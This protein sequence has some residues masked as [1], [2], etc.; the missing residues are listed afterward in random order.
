MMPE[1]EE[2][3][4]EPVAAVE[5]TDET[6]V[7][8]STATEAATVY[9]VVVAE[10]AVAEPLPTEE[11]VTAIADD[12]SLTQPEPTAGTQ[13]DADL[14]SMDNIDPALPEDTSEAATAL[15]TTDTQ[16]SM[17][18]SV[19]TGPSETGPMTA[20]ETPVT[21]DAEETPGFW[22]RLLGSSRRDK[23]DTE[24]AA[25]AETTQVAMSVQPAVAD[26]PVEET[27]AV[28]IETLADQYNRGMM[29]MSNKNFGEAVVLFQSSAAHGYPLAQYQLGTLYYQ[30][31]GVRQDYEEA[32]LW[33]RRAAE[34]QNIDA[35]YSLGNMYLMGEGV[36][37][38]DNQARYWYVRAAEQ[39]HATA[40]HNLDNLSRITA[41][42]EPITPESMQAMFGE[43]EPAGDTM[44][45]VMEELPPAEQIQDTM[46][47]AEETDTQVAAVQPAQPT[48]VPTSLAVVDYERGLAYSFG[49]GVAK[50]P[51]SAFSYFKKAAENN[52]APAQ[53][54]L[55]V[56]YAYAEGTQADLA[57]SAYWYEKAAMQ[58]HT[59]SQ[60][61]L[62]VMYQNGDGVAQD[63]TRALA[64]FSLLADSGNVMDIRRREMLA[65]ELSSDENERAEQLKRELQEQIAAGRQ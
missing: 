15:L 42:G 24:T 40:R 63:K 49:E 4:V 33:Y 19:V 38:D 11:S 1:E 14:M 46:Q 47:S 7:V 16:T 6:A 48:T 8:I 34:Q 39:G 55:G 64:W 59:I 32:A 57:Q 27:A 26:M 10:G 65:S 61:N 50:D 58:G 44:M 31:F 62:G 21:D 23:P 53:Y 17:E 29:E 45:D 9:P 22:E 43:P 30:G 28:S 5:T 12:T 36:R 60:R 41:S 3:E 52:Y 35:Q 20:D 18:E 54:K 13:A 2:A 56:A 25:A 37:Q 51:A